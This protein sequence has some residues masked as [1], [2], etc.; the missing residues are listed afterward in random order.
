[1]V[2]RFGGS[3]K[4]ALKSLRGKYLVVISKN[5]KTHRHFSGLMV[6]RHLQAALRQNQAFSQHRGQQILTKIFSSKQV[7]KTE[8]KTYLHFFYSCHRSFANSTFGIF[9]LRPPFKSL[10]FNFWFSLYRIYPSNS[11]PV[12]LS[13]KLGMLVSNDLIL[14]SK[15]LVV[16]PRLK[17]NSKVVPTKEPTLKSIRATTYEVVL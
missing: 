7:Y 5:K 3:G 16:S 13:R 17:D 9:A 2:K 10:T 4:H 8:Q 6:L 14:R 12:F 1:M 15:P 11:T